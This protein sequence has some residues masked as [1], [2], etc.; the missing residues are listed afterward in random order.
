[1]SLINDAIKRA[2]EAAPPPSV[3]ADPMQAAD[4]APAP[5]L[6]LVLIP[7]LLVTVLGLAVWFLIKGLEAARSV[8]SNQA[9]PVAARENPVSAPSPQPE[10]APVE[11]PTVAAAVPVAPVTSPANPSAT[12]EPPVTTSAAVSPPTPVDPLAELKLQA[13]FY[14]P[15]RPSAVI[16]SKPVGI[17][18]RIGSVTVLSISRETV[19]VEYDGRIRELTVP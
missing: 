18:S 12:G 10:S 9:I 14:Q 1:M 19:V 6:P 3:P 4:Y 15:N 17:G 5:K 11:A 16:N 13:V 7:L 8:S 2:H